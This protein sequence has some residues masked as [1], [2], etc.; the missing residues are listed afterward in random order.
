[1]GVSRFL[2]FY[3]FNSTLVS[4]TSVNKENNPS[5]QEIQRRGN[6]ISSYQRSSHTGE[7]PLEMCVMGCISQGSLEK[8]TNKRLSRYV[9]LSVYLSISLFF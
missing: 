7:L 6:K 2:P 1:M 8:Q 3:N 9:C 4:S 5:L